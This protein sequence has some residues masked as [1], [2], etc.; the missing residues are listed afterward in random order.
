M[1]VQQTTCSLEE[2]LDYENEDVIHRFRTLY[3]MEFHEAEDIFH[4]T[5]KWLWLIRQPDSPPLAIVDGMLILDE[6][7]HNFVL[8][9]REYATYCHERFGRYLHHAPSTHQEKRAYKQRLAAD[10]EGV[11]GEELH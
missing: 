3:D 4:E 11:R 5:K 9:T 7:W 8:F 6:M 2:A 1:N 10:P